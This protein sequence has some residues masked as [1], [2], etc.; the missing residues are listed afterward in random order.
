MWH[1]LYGSAIV[2][3]GQFKFGEKQCIAAQEANYEHA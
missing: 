2:I 1:Y 3:V